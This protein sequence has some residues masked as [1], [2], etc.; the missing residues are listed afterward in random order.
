[1]AAKTCSVSYRLEITEEELAKIL[2]NGAVPDK[3]I[4]HIVHLL[5]EAPIQVVV[6]AVEQ[7]ASARSM[8]II[9][10]WRNIESLSKAIES[11]RCGAWGLE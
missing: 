5:D 7:V 2:S 4:S 3:F 8:P 9:E 10:V 1:M 11:R 6:M